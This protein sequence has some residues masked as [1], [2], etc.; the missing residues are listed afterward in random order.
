MS[1]EEYATPLSKFQDFR[2]NSLSVTSDYVLREL[3]P[4][5][6]IDNSLEKDARDEL[7]Q[8]VRKVTKAVEYSWTMADFCAIGLHELCSR[9]DSWNLG[10]MPLRI[11]VDCFVGIKNE[12][13]YAKANIIDAKVLYE[14]AEKDVEPMLQE[15]DEVLVSFLDNEEISESQP[16]DTIPTWRN[17]PPDMWGHL[18]CAVEQLDSDFAELMKAYSSWFEW[19]PKAPERRG[20]LAKDRAARK[21]SVISPTVKWR[22]PEED[23]DTPFDVLVQAVGEIGNC[24]VKVSNID[25]IADNVSRVTLSLE[26]TGSSQEALD[27]VTLRCWKSELH[28]SYSVR[29]LGLGSS[30]LDK[31]PTAMKRWFGMD[32]APRLS[33]NFTERRAEWTVRRRFLGNLPAQFFLSL[34]ADYTD[35]CVLVFDL[36]HVYKNKRLNSTPIASNTVLRELVPLLAVNSSLGKDA[37][38]ELEQ[39]VR[40][41]TKAV[42]YTWT[43]ATFF[44]IGLHQLCAR[45][46]SWNPG[47]I[48]LRRILDHLIGIMLELRY[49]QANMNDAKALYEEAEKDVEP[50][51][52]NHLEQFGPDTII[53]VAS[54]QCFG[55]DLNFQTVTLKTITDN[56]LK[57]LRELIMT[58]GFCIQLLQEIDEVLVS[59]LDNEEITGSQPLDAIPTWRTHPPEMW[60]H[61][62]CAV[63]GVVY[64]LEQVVKAYSSWFEWIPNATDTRLRLADDREARESSVAS[65]TSKW[66]IPEENPKIPLDILVQAV[67]KIGSCVVKLSNVEHI[68]DNVSRMTFSLEFTGS[69]QDTLDHV[70]L[71]C[72]ESEFHPSY[73]VR[74]KALG[75]SGLD[76]RPTAVK[77]WFGMDQAPRLSTNFTETRAE[78]TIQRRFLGNLPAQFSLSLDAD[79][80]DACVLTFELSHVYKNKRCRRQSS[81][82]T[83]PQGRQN[84]KSA[85]S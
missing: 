12:L 38:D 1:V 22:L 37:R 9:L 71:Q 35:A 3:V 80:T 49:A 53:K 30:G 34:D 32:Q 18:Y 51:F 70:T 23:P 31:R 50:L 61:L 65:P 29:F 27:L 42:G 74:F 26:F 84:S 52:R 73:S 60:G 82:I 41:I 76:K 46:N 59:F 79:Y 75:S 20:R 72:F 56:V 21:S 33:T 57:N 11:L 28:T 10:G 63:E 39:V 77:R 36:S 83:I 40:K 19:I 15:I 81:D 69:S 8:V 2:L 48:P 68:A 58:A 25:H 54:K 43:M 78:W 6:A 4:L 44:A 64:D 62:Y 45:L 14:E 66:R 7:E 85:H 17:H 67:G 55:D 16:L 5:L 24:I 13:R 47:K